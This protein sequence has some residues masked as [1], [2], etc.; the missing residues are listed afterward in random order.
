MTFGFQPG[1]V[2]PLESLCRFSGSSMLS[3]LFAFTDSGLE[4]SRGLGAEELF[5]EVKEYA[6]QK[7]MMAC[8]TEFL[9]FPVEGS[10]YG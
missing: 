1:H 5:G 8:L 4:G 10:C 2:I 3:S 6:V 7:T 9:A